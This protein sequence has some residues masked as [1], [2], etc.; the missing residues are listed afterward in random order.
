MTRAISIFANTEE[1]G[2]LQQ[3]F[4]LVETK[5]T[6]MFASRNKN[7]NAFRILNIISKEI[8]GKKQ[9]FKLSKMAHYLR[10]PHLLHGLL[11]ESL[12]Y[13]TYCINWAI[14]SPKLKMV[15]INKQTLVDIF[16]QLQ[17]L[18]NLNSLYKMIKDHKKCHTHHYFKI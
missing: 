12:W 16:V 15:D 11:H 1:E 14:F 4:L 6:T 2:K 3:Q 7:N 17:V 5:T 9:T 13:L 10:V 18:K 8:F